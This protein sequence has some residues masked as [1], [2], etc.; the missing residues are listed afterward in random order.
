MLHIKI[1]FF[2]VLVMDF[3]EK[4]LNLRSL[5]TRQVSIEI[6]TLQIHQQ[7]SQQLL[8]PCTRDLIQRNVQ[9]LHLMLIFNMN[10]YTL[11]FCI[12][13]ILQHR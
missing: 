2:D 6:H 12:S 13:Q 9:R 10:H 5:K 8:I 1:I 4:L 11:N 7:V 3:G